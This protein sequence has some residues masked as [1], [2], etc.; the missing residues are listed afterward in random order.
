MRTRTECYVVIETGARRG[1]APLHMHARGP[2][3]DA[4][5]LQVICG[6][7]HTQESGQWDQGHTELS[8]FL[9]YGGGAEW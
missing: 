8:S 1:E 6:N 7:R 9:A 4:D 5:L 2:G 3:E